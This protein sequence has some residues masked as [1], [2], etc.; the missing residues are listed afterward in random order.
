MICP[1]DCLLFFFYLFFKKCRLSKFCFFFLKYNN[2]VQFMSR[3]IQTFNQTFSRASV[4]NEI[5]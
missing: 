1:L 2:N 5:N 4:N 3:E